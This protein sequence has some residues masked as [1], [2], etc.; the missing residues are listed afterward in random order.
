VIVLS[1][2]TIV[3]AGWLDA[4]MRCA[5]TD[6]RTG[7]ITP[8]SNNAGICSFPEFC[9]SN[10]VP[11]DPELIN[12]AMK[13]AAVP[14][15]PELPTAA[16]FCMFI[17]RRLI[18]KIGVFDPELC[19]AHREANDFS[20]RARNAGYRNVLCDDAYVVHVGSRSGPAAGD[21]NPAQVLANHPDDVHLVREFIAKDPIRPIRAMVH[22]QLALLANER[23]PGVL[24]VVHPRGGGTE[25][26][27]QELISVSH[28]YRHYF[29]R[30]H[31]DR[32][33]VTD[34]GDADSANYAWSRHGDDPDRAWLRSI[35]AWLRIG[36]V[37]VHSL[38]GSG[39]DFL[40]VLEEASVPYCYSV[41]DMYLPCPTVYLI[42][43]EGKYCDATTDHA[44]CRQCLS[45]FS[46]LKDT[47]VSR[48]RARYRGFLDNASKVY[49]PSKWAGDTLARYYPGIEVTL[50]P[51]WTEPARNE[52]VGEVSNAFD[53]PNDACRHIGVLGAIG[54]EKGARHLEALVARIRER[55][56]PLRIVVIGY[57]DRD[58]R[59]QSSDQVLTIHGPYRREEVEA[60]FDW[61]RIALVAFPT[62]WPETFSYT[63]SEGWMAGRPALVPPRGALQERILATGAGWLMEGWPDADA[64]LD[65]LMALT[66]P[67]NAPEL[68]R[69]ARLAKAVFREGPREAES[70]GILYR[71]MLADVSK[72]A[73]R[74]VSRYRIYE[75]ACRA[76]GMAPSPPAPNRGP[77]APVHRRTMIANLV[78]LL[79]A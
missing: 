70:T 24:H 27:I 20:M 66:A 68:E 16:G 11:E 30:I 9:R 65:Q 53:L 57:T 56:L 6:A 49:A 17:G 38:V 43:S 32:W 26:Y 41:H 71:D 45:K 14:V 40:Q 1:S 79:R 39:D 22:S 73:E 12:R 59:H 78:R 3:T 34:A 10:L 46:G 29:L 69:R 42:N 28:D 18:R 51:P 8:F 55:R 60:L 44:L 72:H 4:I 48:W 23:K 58:S 36:V 50:A 63:L 13:L 7:T 19:E 67:E 31:P 15:Y 61:Y 21:D 62:V 76:L 35:C 2:E 5:A 77:T 52:P 74:A 54:P 37:H 75:A 64:I 47:D 25:K 33:L